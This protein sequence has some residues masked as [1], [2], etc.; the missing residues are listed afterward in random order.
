MAEQMLAKPRFV[1]AGPMRVC[2]LSGEFTRAMV[3]EIPALW[4]RFNEQLAA[5]KP[6]GR[7]GDQT[8]GVVYPLAVMRYVC[9]AQMEDGAAG[10]EG[11]V[12]VTVPAAQYA[13][14]SGTGGILA[15][16]QF[17]I[18]IFSEWLPNS[19]V[20]QADGPMVECYPG[21]WID[22]GNFEIW[23]PVLA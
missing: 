13:V 16:R 5:V 15:I 8:Y 14:F 18:A 4:T 1:D 17:W 10:P 6:D 2:G 9:G 12:E 19:G 23:I 7:V 22:S 21:D 20:Q 11:W 3:G